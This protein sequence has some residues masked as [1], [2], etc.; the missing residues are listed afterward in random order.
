MKALSENDVESS[1]P[2][3]T[4]VEDQVLPEEDVLIQND[5]S[6]EAAQNQNDM[7]R[8]VNMKDS[9]HER[10]SPQ[11]RATPKPAPRTRLPENANPEQFKC[12]ICKLMRDTKE[13]LD[14]HMKNHT[15]EGVWTCDECS[16]QSHDQNALLNHM[17]EKRHSSKLLDHILNKNI[18]NKK[19]K[20]NFC[21]QG[22]SNKRE[23]EEHKMKNHKSYKPCRNIPRCDWGEHCLYNHKEIGENMF[24]CY[25][26]GDEFDTRHKMMMHIKVAHKSKVCKDFI[27]G[28]S[29]RFTPCWYSHDNKATTSA[30]VQA[31]RTL[32]QTENPPRPGFWE[33]RP[34]NAPPKQPEQQDLRQAIQLMQE[35]QQQQQKQM[36]Q[37]M[38]MMQQLMNQMRMNHQ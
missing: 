25:Q 7:V 16:Y 27:E 24:V 8:L 1:M 29:C 21:T 19:Y 33:T 30:P 38:E 23:L 13:K 26:C 18:Y 10:E 4:N 6:N 20:C 5:I 31:G 32:T 15:E 28:R 37:Q 35:Q 12:D 14:R 11:A 3:D 2:R 9:G 22:F 34:S 17:L 36:Q